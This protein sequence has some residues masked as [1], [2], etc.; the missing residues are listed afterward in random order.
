MAVSLPT[1]FNDSIGQTAREAE[2]TG[3]NW[4]NGVNLGGGNSPGV[5]INQGQ[6]AVVGT[7]A[8]FTLL[9]QYETSRAPQISQVIGGTGY[10]AAS[11][12]PSSG[13]IAGNG[14]ARGEFI[15][16]VTPSASG[17]GSAVTNGT[18]NLAS[19]AA[20]WTAA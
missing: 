12:Y 20:G 7:P 3:A 11:A 13:G 8:Q 4:D 18:A 19:L 16:V 1:K 6:G 9:D 5:G 15:L 10:V 14:D 17:D 2:V